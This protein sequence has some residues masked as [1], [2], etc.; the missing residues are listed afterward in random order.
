MYIRQHG[1]KIP[2]FTKLKF[3]PEAERRARAPAV[4]QWRVEFPHLSQAYDVAISYARG[5][6]IKPKDFARIVRRYKPGR[7]KG[8]PDDK[9]DA[10]ARSPTGGGRFVDGGGDWSDHQS[11]T[12]SDDLDDPMYDAED[13]LGDT[14]DAEDDPMYDAEDDPEGDPEQDPMCDPEDNPARRLI[15]PMENNL[16]ADATGVAYSVVAPHGT[17]VVAWTAEPVIITADEALASEG[18][19]GDGQ[20]RE[21]P[22]RDDAIKWLRNLLTDGPCGEGGTERGACRRY[23]YRNPTPRQ[24]GDPD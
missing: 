2:K 20:E 5:E 22:E 10:L 24:G 9:R 6:R 1:V 12:L 8:L 23:Q 13:D 16:A 21:R 15:L 18:R 19:D 17:P 4:E 11:A 3:D 14:Y 7:G